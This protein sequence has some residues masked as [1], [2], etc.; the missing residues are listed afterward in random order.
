MNWKGIIHETFFSLIFGTY[1]VDSDEK[2][3]LL[4]GSLKSGQET[5][6]VKIN[7]EWWNIVKWRNTSLTCSRPW[8]SIP[9]VPKRMENLHYFT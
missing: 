2:I 8:D 6:F 5:I 7:Y 9:S 1:T 4:G 3:F